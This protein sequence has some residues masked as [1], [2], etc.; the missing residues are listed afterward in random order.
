MSVPRVRAER[1]EAFADRRVLRYWTLV[2]IVN[3]WPQDP[4]R[5]FSMEAWE[6]YAQALRA[7]SRA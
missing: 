2:G 6:W 3:G 1:I 5:R 4:G 7:H